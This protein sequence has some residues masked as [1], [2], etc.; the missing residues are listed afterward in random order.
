MRLTAFNEILHIND[1]FEDLKREQRERR[2]KRMMIVS[3]LFL[4]ILL[5][6][7]LGI[8]LF[9]ALYLN[10]TPDGEYKGRLLVD[11]PSRT[12]TITSKTSTSSVS[13]YTTTKRVS[14]VLSSKPTV[15]RS[16]KGKG[17]PTAHPKSGSSR[18]S[19]SSTSRKTIIVTTNTL[20]TTTSTST[21]TN[22]TTPKKTTTAKKPIVPPTPSW[23]KT[24]NGKTYQF[25]PTATKWGDA[26]ASC[27]PPGSLASL[28][29]TDTRYVSSLIPSNTAV[30]V[31]ATCS[32]TVCIWLDG[33]KLSV[34]GQFSAG[35]VQIENGSFTS[36][37]CNQTKAFLCERK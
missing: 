33:T 21:T 15:S 19:S 22:K 30:W 18:T 29:P 35:C 28:S 34:I 1:N 26:K 12:G 31:G 17:S 2:R 20:K 13:S 3:V 24:L 10:R 16:S 23:H 11:D 5:F 37:D 14:S 4:L 8:V 25:N 36:A 32:D 6:V 9:L 27:S 7:I